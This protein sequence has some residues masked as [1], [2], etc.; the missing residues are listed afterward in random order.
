MSY[1]TIKQIQAIYIKIKNIAKKEFENKNYELSL[2]QVETAAELAYMFNWIYTDEELEN[3]LSNISIAILG[4]MKKPFI[5]ITGRVVFYDVFALD[6]RGLTQQ[7]LRAFIS[8]GVEIL[9]IFEGK[10]LVYSKKIIE[11]LSFY[12][13]AELF[14]VD[15]SLSRVKKIEDIYKKII[16]FKPEK[17]FLHLH[18][19]SAVAVTV[20]SSLKEVTRYQINLTDHAFWLGAKCIDYSLEFRDYG[21]TVSSERRGLAENML[22]L[23]PYYPILD[24][25]PFIGFPLQIPSD[26]IKIFTGGAYYKMY[27]KS[28]M[29]FKLLSSLIC[30]NPKVIILLAGNGDDKPLKDFINKNNF[31][32]K[33]FLLG[34]RPDITYVFENIDIYLSTF[35]ITGGLMGQFAATL[36]KP[37]LSYSSEDIPNNFLEGFINWNRNSDYKLTHTDIDSF[38]N[39]AL[40]LIESKTY[41]EEKGQEIKRHIITE[42]EF[43]INLKQLVTSNKVEKPIKKVSINY[44][45]LFKLYLENENYYLKKIHFFIVSRFKIKAIFLFPKNVIAFIV[46]LSNWQFFFS[47][48]LKVK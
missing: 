43:S 12:S 45:V 17:A 41:R 25:K 15:T 37:I 29:F 28:D 5:P 8:W 26:A 30:L 42:R 10:N 48:F 22:L 9:F 27:G 11:E 18:P 4:E 3:N 31:H 20:W 40:K 39:D 33:L 19:A 7:Y 46:D 36:A 21:C 23:Q 16:E 6:N 14:V 35:P 44:D 1:L 24:C 34:S 38:M 32:N 2:K 47:K 13:K